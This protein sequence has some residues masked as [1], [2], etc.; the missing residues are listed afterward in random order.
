MNETIHDLAR[1]YLSEKGLPLSDAQK[2]AIFEFADWV[3]LEK[4]DEAAPACPDCG[5]EMFVH[6]HDCPQLA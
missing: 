6:H 2:R 4:R 1:R 3:L 5:S